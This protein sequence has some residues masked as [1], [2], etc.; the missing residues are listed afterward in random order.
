MALTQTDRKKA[1][2]VHFYSTLSFHSHSVRVCSLKVIAPG[3]RSAYYIARRFVAH[4][5]VT[6]LLSDGTCGEGPN[7]VLQH[8]WFVAARSLVGH[9]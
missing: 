5:Y 4:S 2:S 3:L 8:K 7:C 6:Y 9:Y 1:S